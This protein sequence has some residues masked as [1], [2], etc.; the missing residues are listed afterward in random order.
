MLAFWKGWNY[1]APNDLK[2]DDFNEILWIE[3]D[4]EADCKQCEEL[5]EK[6]DIEMP[7]DVYSIEE[8]LKVKSF[9]LVAES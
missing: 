8:I 2:I 3:I 1:V 9:V 5:G 4:D 6:L 7:T